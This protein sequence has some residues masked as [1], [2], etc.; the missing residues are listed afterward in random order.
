MSAHGPGAGELHQT[1][2]ENAAG[3]EAIFVG[4]GTIVPHPLHAPSCLALRAPACTVAVDL[5]A[6][7]LRGLTQAGIQVRDLD[8]LLLTHAHL[9]HIGDLFSL[10][11]LLRVGLAT[12]ERPLEIVLSEAAHALLSGVWPT[13]GTWLVPEEGAVTW[14]TLPP[15]SSLRRPGVEVTTR[16]MVHD[17]TSIGYRLSFD[18]G[19]SVAVP[20]DTAA[21]AG[22][23]AL[24]AEVDLAVVEC[25]YAP[26]RESTSH[27]NLNDVAALLRR[28]RPATVAIVHRYAD[29]LALDVAAA[30]RGSAGT[31]LVPVD[32]DTWL[33][34]SRRTGAQPA[35]R[36]D[37]VTS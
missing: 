33:I 1:A 32:G 28:A 37:R 6:G 14:T 3:V 9:D 23:D 16:A 10:L 17:E 22:L 8:L 2:R 31:V 30:L 11:F 34:E 5:G 36:R 25:S 19:V 4:T 7:A 12:R 26:G 13:L 35:N 20:G 24:C 29:A 27:L 15:G 21:C 18:A